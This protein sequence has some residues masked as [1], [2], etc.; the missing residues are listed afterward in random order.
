MATPL[1]P[2]FTP[3]VIG[4]S[5]TTASS[6]TFAGLPQ[7][8]TV[9]APS[10]DQFHITY[11]GGAGYDVD[12]T[13]LLPTLAINNASDAASGTASTT[14]TLTATLSA[15]SSQTVTVNYATANG[16][17]IAGTD[18]TAASGTLT[19]APGQT[20]QSI[21]IAVLKATAYEADRTFTVTLSSPSSNATIGTG[22]GVGTGTITEDHQ[23]PVVSDANA[24]ATE[25]VTGT[26]SLLVPV[27]LTAASIFPVTVNYATANGTAHSGTDYNAASGTITFTPGQTVQTATITILNDGAVSADKTFTV[28][29][30]SPAK[31]TLGTAVATA[32]IID[33]SF[34]PTLKN[35]AA[36]VA[37][38]FA[39]ITGQALGGEPSAPV[40]RVAVNGKEVDAIDAAGDFFA[41]VT[42]PPGVN[43]FTVIA[44]DAAGASTPVTLTVVALSPVPAGSIN[45]ALLSDVT[46]SFSAT[47]ART[48]FADG[49]A[50][51]YADVTAKDIGTYSVDTPLLVGISHISDPTV[52]LLNP[53]GVTPATFSP[54]GVPYYDLSSLVPGGSLAP[55]Q[56]TN[57]FTLAFSDPNKDRFTYTLDFFAA[58]NK[59][60]VF[61]TVPVVTVP[62]G[63]SYAYAS[64]A[65]D[66]DSDASR[67]AYSIV[68]GPSGMTINAATGAV[69]WTASATGGNY[70]IDLRVN[71]G[72]GGV[73]DQ[74]Y[75][76][77]VVAGA[78]NT[79]P[80]FITQPVVSANVD[81]AY[82][83]P[84]QAVD[85]DG[86]SP[87]VY[88]ATTVPPGMMVNGST[89]AVTWTPTYQ[90][91]G[92]NKV[93][94]QV[95]DGH[96]NI[97]YQ[98]Y[99]ITVSAES[100]NTP[101]YITSTPPLNAIPNQTYTYPVRAEDQDGDT[102]IYSLVAGDYPPTMTINPST[103]AISW[104]PTSA[105]TAS[106]HPVTVRVDDGFGGYDT[107]S[108]TITVS[109][110][111]GTIQ[112]QVTDV[113]AVAGAPATSHCRP[114]RPRPR[115][116]SSRSL[117]RS[118]TCPPWSMRSPPTR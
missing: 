42:L 40:N 16:T 37:N 33:D 20:T 24:S 117:L 75:V 30:L 103:G 95:T 108:Y 64:Q 116:R 41:H 61:D 15:A 66:P 74:H 78:P 5:S 76:L 46:P 58:I 92:L 115:S 23:A 17:A 89:G 67:L 22:V 88:A 28:T 31:A 52:Q 90:E 56:S 35:V 83:Y 109:T 11:V 44:Y 100:G 105:D 43:T 106:P 18:Y 12:L 94:I 99:T 29:I 114:P 26:G 54:A 82:L 86:D 84:S 69:A 73:G 79:P 39:L 107:Q 110:N 25:P 62:A 38:G 113:A 51:L 70:D 98:S 9:T 48:S 85:D 93:T 6:G 21:A 19:F 7:G 72:R 2:T 96:G 10:G 8:A 91:L 87:L 71:D 13:H 111:F 57:T 97:A 81:T 80:R 49:P 101:P 68:A 34:L 27:T 60:P 55:G 59:P 36:S 77:T 50:V 65:Y 63:D 112:G 45:F 118:S 53:P 102:L 32:T 4:N 14:L 3:T 47:Y 104:T 1:P